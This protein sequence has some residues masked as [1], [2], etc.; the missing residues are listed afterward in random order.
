VTRDVSELGPTVFQDTALPAR[1]AT[2][3]F[4]RTATYEVLYV[5]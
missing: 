2:I 4:P 3:S 1:T 5:M